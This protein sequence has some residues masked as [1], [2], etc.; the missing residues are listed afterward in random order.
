MILVRTNR[1][2]FPAEVWCCLADGTLHI[3]WFNGLK[4]KFSAGGAIYPSW[5]DDTGVKLKEVF[6][7]SP[8]P[9]Q[10]EAPVW[11]IIP[12]SDVVGAPWAVEEKAGKTY[13]PAPAKAALQAWLA[14][15]SK[16]HR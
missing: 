12:I 7:H 4:G 11:T 1:G 14:V 5:L 2:V 16:K 6:T 8:S 15:P 13:L 10:E 9:A 3:H